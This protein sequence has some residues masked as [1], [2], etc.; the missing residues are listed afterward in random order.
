MG[1][2]WIDRQWKNA[3]LGDKRREKRAIKIGEACL[4]LPNGTLPEKFC[5]WGDTKGAYRFFDSP[6]VTHEAL[7]QVHNKNVIE[8]AAGSNQM[9]LFIKDGSELLYNKHPCTYGLGPTADAYGQGIMFHT[10]LAVEWSGNFPPLTIGVAKQTAWIR[11][12]PSEKTEDNDQKEKESW[13]WLNT[14]KAIGRPPVNSRWISVGDRNNDIYEYVL[15]A[16][17]DGWDYTLRA[18]HDRTI[19]VNGEKKRLHKWVRNLEPKGE[20]KLDLRA[21]G[22]K[23]SRQAELK[24]A[25]GEA[26]MQPPNGNK[27][28]AIEVTYVRSYD[29]ED[30]DLEWILVT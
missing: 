15:G 8:M 7:Q 23:F 9:V 2:K 22:E 17:N 16:T 6:K 26:V 13:L 27:G 11:P 18:K 12:E 5:S 28:K 24:I 30:K 21:R 29:P 1:N 20:Y 14:L 10:C 25:W 4:N 3:P 19:L